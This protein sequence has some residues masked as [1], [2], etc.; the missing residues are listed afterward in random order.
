MHDARPN[1]KYQWVCMFVCVLGF[2]GT[3]SADGLDDARH[4]YAANGDHASLQVLASHLKKGMTRAQA[5]ALLG[6]PDDEPVTGQL[7]YGTNRKEFVKEDGVEMFVYLVLDFRDSSDEPID[8]L[9]GWGF[10]PLGE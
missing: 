2:L 4:K 8:E 5:E 7:R 6:S 10:A 9:Q 3:V 1:S